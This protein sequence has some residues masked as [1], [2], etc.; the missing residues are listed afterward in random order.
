M[1]NKL[2]DKIYGSLIGAAIGDAMGGPVEMLDY[3]EIKESYGKVNQL[4]YYNNVELSPHGPWAKEAGNYTD[5]TRL[6]NLIV[7]A[8]IDKQGNISDKELIKEVSKYFHNAS[9]GLEKEW[10]EEYYYKAIYQNDKLAFGGQPQNAGVMAL[11][12]IGIINICDPD[13]AFEEAFKLS[14]FVE[15]YSKYSGAFA[16]ALSAT[17]FIPNIQND[18]IISKSM[19]AMYEYKKSVEGPRWFNTDLYQHVGEENEKIINRAIKIAKKYKDP[20]CTE[21][22]KEIYDNALQ[23]Y[24]YDGAETVALTCS[25]LAFE[26]LSFED[27]VSAAVCLGRDNDSSAT[28]VGAVAGAKY[29]A[30]QIPQKWIDTIE[31]VNKDFMQIKEQAEN[32]TGIV[33]SKL[34]KQIK[35]IENIKKIANIELKEKSNIR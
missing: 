27:A 33:E 9:E 13:K 4:L 21:F 8:I 15:S 29:G 19:S 20:F 16:A 11:Q 22:Q 3:D 24:K 14:F 5:D 2:F 31:T 28:L 17:A 30:S 23:K 26:N 35:I 6:R 25:I 1:N 10:I 7:N 12:P 32:L 18:E 34:A